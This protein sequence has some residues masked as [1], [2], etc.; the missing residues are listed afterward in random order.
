MSVLITM[1]SHEKHAEAR[2]MQ[3][4]CDNQALQMQPPPPFIATKAHRVT[5]A[6]A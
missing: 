5:A 2:G 1:E 3:T 4:A 6:E